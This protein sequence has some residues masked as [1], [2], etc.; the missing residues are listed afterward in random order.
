MV[1]N[2][3]HTENDEHSACEMVCI[4]IGQ[5]EGGPLLAALVLYA[6]LKV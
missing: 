5:P 6:I 1:W 3:G 4:E 2:F